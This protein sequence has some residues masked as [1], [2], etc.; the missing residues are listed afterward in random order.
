M[1][2]LIFLLLTLFSSS[3][4]EQLITPKISE[5]E[6][7]PKV[8]DQLYD[9]NKYWK[10]FE[11]NDPIL[12]KR[13]CF[14]KHTDLIQLHLS[15]VEKHLRSKEVTHLSIAQKIKRNIGLNILKDYWQSGKFPINNHH[16]EQVIPY[17]IDDFNTAC[18][19]GHIVRET[20]FGEFTEK[21][22]RENNYAYIEDLDYPE[23][24]SWANDF[25]F[26]EMELRWIQPGYGCWANRTEILVT[27]TNISGFGSIT[28]AFSQANNDSNPN[29]IRFDLPA[30]SVIY[31]TEQLWMQGTCDAIEGYLLNG[32]GNIIIDGT[33]F[34]NTYWGIVINAD[35]CDV[36]N[37]S[38]RNYPHSAMGAWEKNNISFQNNI[39]YANQNGIQVAGGAQNISIKFNTI[40]VD[41]NMN[42]NQPLNSEEYGIWI[43]DATSISISNNTI[44]GIGG[45]GHY[46]IVLDSDD[47]GSDIIISGN[48][49]GV[50]EVGNTVIPN[51]YVFWLETTKV[52]LQLLITL[53]QVMKT[54]EF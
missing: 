46:G 27:N 9:L 43:D 39:L 23:L 53:F 11:I 20:G 12:Q 26:D 8:Y 6:N 31:P 51:H 28:W 32:S 19:V 18:A 45:E 36:S 24:T 42:N 3:T 48:K 5:N 54:Q 47:I 44:S 34:T 7:C 22:R 52:M 40:G 41:E 1:N 4:T 21:V 29:V 2:N 15:L 14:E 35:D 13:I 10:S 37:L 17:F 33:N 16:P 25:G 49:I 30:N 38:V 50:D